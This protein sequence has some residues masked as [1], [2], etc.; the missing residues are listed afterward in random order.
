MD[1]LG[2]GA[3]ARYDTIDGNSDGPT[4]DVQI[5]RH[6]VLH[7]SL[8]PLLIPIAALVYPPL[9]ISIPLGNGQALSQLEYEWGYKSSFILKKTPIDTIYNGTKIFEYRLVPLPGI[10][11]NPIF[12]AEDAYPFPYI[13]LPILRLPILPHF[14][15]VDFALKYAKHDMFKIRS[16]AETGPYFKNLYE[17][18]SGCDCIYQTWLMAKVPLPFLQEFGD[19]DTWRAVGPG[20]NPFRRKDA[21]V[22]LPED[23]ASIWDGD[24]VGLRPLD[25]ITHTSDGGDDDSD[26]GEDENCEEDAERYSVLNARVRQWIGDIRPY[27]TSSEGHRET[28]G[29]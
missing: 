22:F 5:E 8:S 15:M 19:D 16:T 17:E 4:T 11:R 3:S 29:K 28:R 7:S 21:H 12:H 10:T 9:V 6:I 20:G 18:L 25:S 23:P 13:T 26:Q 14:A 24:R 27:P 1:K 2:T